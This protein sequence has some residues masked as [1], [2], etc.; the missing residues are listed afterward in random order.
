M[1][2][3]SKCRRIKDLDDWAEKSYGS[4][5]KY[6]QNCSVEGSKSKR[7]YCVPIRF[8]CDEAH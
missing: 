4:Y 8:S 2:A 6:R 5:D 1:V 7:F 3:M